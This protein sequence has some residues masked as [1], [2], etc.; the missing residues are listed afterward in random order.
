M[1]MS[2]V[3]RAVQV[4]SEGDAHALL[5]TTCP[6]QLG[7]SPRGMSSPR[8]WAHIR[9][10]APFTVAVRLDVL[11]LSDPL[12]IGSFGQRRCGR[13]KPIRSLYFRTEGHQSSAP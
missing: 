2:W 11:P 10:S 9:F 4:G 3:T 1:L 6:R 5:A 8:S 12:A 13:S 7:T